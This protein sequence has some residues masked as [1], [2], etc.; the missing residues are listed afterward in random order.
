[1]TTTSPDGEAAPADPG[2]IDISEIKERYDDA[3]RTADNEPWDFSCDEDLRAIVMEDHPNLIAA[4]EALRDRVLVEALQSTK[5][6]E[7]ALEQKNRAEA[8]QEEVYALNKVLSAFG[9]ENKALRARVV[10]LQYR[11]RNL[12][13]FSGNPRT[14]MYGPRP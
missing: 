9:V 3:R 6:L 2:A 10:E 5:A 13:N 14:T 12:M 1:M 11:A 8:A 4:V 7:Q